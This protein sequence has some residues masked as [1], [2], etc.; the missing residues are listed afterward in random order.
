MGRCLAGVKRGHLLRGEVADRRGLLL[1]FGGVVDVPDLAER[2][3]L[4]AD[5]L[6]NLR[7]RLAVVG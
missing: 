7:A 6:G 3:A 4:H 5:L 2:A 1:V